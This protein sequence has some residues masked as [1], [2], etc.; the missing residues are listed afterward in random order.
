MAADQRDQH[1][2]EPTAPGSIRRT[3]LSPRGTKVALG[4]A[5]GSANSARARACA[6][7]AARPRRR[8]AVGHGEIRLLAEALKGPVRVHA[9]IAR[10]GPHIAGNEAGGFKGLTSAILDRGD[11]GG[12]DLQFALH[13]QQ[14]LAQRRALTAHHIAQ[15][16]FEIVKALRLLL[17]RCLRFG[18]PAD[19]A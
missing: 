3:Q 8:H 9:Q 18:P 10:I 15:A 11:I 14:R 4:L 6:D 12:L 13:V 2:T 1:R 5:S 16:K 19:H 7:A 17:F